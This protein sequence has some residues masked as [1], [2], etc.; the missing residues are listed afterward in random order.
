MKTRTFYTKIDYIKNKIKQS[1]L[2]KARIH[3]LM[4]GKG[5]PRLWVKWFI[6]PL[7]FHHGRKIIIRHNT[8]MNV[9]PINKFR[10]GNR[11]IIEEYTVVDN[12][13]GDVLIGE[14]SLVGLRNTIIGPVE[15]GNHVILAQNVVLSGLN[16]SYEDI[17]TPIHLQGVVTKKITIEDGVWIA[18]NSIIMAGVNIGKNSVI[19]GG[20]VVTKD[21]PPFTV[22]A[23]N[24]AKTIKILNNCHTTLP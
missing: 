11:S 8:V 20:S 24:P 5:R 12:G 10:L 2:W 6:N 1:P 18:A 17:S 4:F 3:K 22:V 14:D 7:L 23:G 19:A 9:S 15:I 13:V 21:V 16:H